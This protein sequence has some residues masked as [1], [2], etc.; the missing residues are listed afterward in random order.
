M[1]AEINDE[2]RAVS[3]RVIKLITVVKQCERVGGLVPANY[4]A[5]I[6]FRVKWD[7]TVELPCKFARS[8]C[9]MDPG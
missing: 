2:T 4:P 1:R 6:F 3:S 8:K 9:G 5:K 7:T